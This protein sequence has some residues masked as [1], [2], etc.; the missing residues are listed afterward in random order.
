MLHELIGILAHLEEV[1]FFLCIHAFPA[2]VGALAVHQ[3]TF[4]PEAFTGGAVLAHIFSLVNIALFIHLGED[5]LHLG[6]VFRVS[7]ADKA[8]VGS[9]HQIPNILD[10]PCHIVHIFLGS[11]AGSFRLLLNFLTVLIG[12]GLEIHIKAGLPLIAGYGIG[13]YDLVSIADVGL[14]RS[15][16][17]SRCNVIRFLFHLI[18]LKNENRPCSKA[19]TIKLTVVPP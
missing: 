3:L 10:L 16:C 6:F 4:G 5:L 19:R 13:Q 9:V 12:A 17:N 18:L 8:V 15:V 7:G 1:G 14:C 11:N 2:A